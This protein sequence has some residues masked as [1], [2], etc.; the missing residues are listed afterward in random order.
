MGG[1]LDT[2][3]SQRRTC[4]EKRPEA[5]Q[6]RTEVERLKKN[7]Q[8]KLVSSGASGSNDPEWRHFSE[9]LSLIARGERG[10]AHV[11]LGTALQNFSRRDHLSIR[12]LALRARIHGCCG[13]NAAKLQLLHESILSY[14]KCLEDLLQLDHR[15]GKDVTSNVRLPVLLNLGYLH[16][17][18]G[19]KD[20]AQ[21]FYKLAANLQVTCPTE[22][23]ATA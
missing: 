1:T 23:T 3:A 16:L 6:H 19:S 13:E 21:E 12:E 7:L 5:G 15:A 14:E 2:C 9:A 11:R 4:S 10:K 20:T 17:Q 22:I 18:T 8:T